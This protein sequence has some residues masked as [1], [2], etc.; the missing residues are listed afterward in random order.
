MN[1][2]AFHTFLLCFTIDDTWG[3]RNP[4]YRSLLSSERGL[5]TYLN[6]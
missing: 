3:L 6:N 2:T 4:K 5:H 1:L